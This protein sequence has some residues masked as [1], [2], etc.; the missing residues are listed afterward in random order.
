MG[1]PMCLY[2]LVYNST[3]SER[4]QKASLNFISNTSWIIVDFYI[5]TQNFI[6]ADEINPVF[7]SRWSSLISFGNQGAWYFK[8]DVHISSEFENTHLLIFVCICHSSS[9]WFTGMCVCWGKRKEEEEEGM[10]ISMLV[11]F[12]RLVGAM[13]YSVFL[14]NLDEG[15][16]YCCAYLFH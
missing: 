11:N 12:V 6:V 7:C 14:F 1:C 9:S 15:A 3:Q 13:A 5:L 10:V 8:D 2:Q 4:N 16:S